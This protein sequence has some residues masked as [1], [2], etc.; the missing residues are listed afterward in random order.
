VRRGTWCGGRENGAAT[1]GERTAAAHRALASAS[2]CRG[3]RHGGEGRKANGD[4][5]LHAKLW[6][7][8][9]AT[10]RRWSSKPAALPSSAVKAVS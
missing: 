5:H 9:R 2:N 8:A 10:E 1:G 4:P 3:R 6:Q 7:Q